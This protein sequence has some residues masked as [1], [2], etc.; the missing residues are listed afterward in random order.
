MAKPLAQHLCDGLSQQLGLTRYGVFYDSLALT[1][2]P[3]A[4]AVLV[5]TGFMTHPQEFERL[6]TPAFQQAFAQTLAN[7]TAAFIAGSINA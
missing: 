4:M 5:E 7:L 2:I 1:R 6:Q 3:Q